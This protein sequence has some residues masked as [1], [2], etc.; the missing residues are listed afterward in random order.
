MEQ[1]LAISLLVIA[2]IL[3]VITGILANS[4]LDYPMVLGWPG[5]VYMVATPKVLPLLVVLLFITFALAHGDFDWVIAAVGVALGAISSPRLSDLA[6]A[7]FA[8]AR[9]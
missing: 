9:P 6:K 3:G 7:K 5:V 1:F 2:F 8:K 4:R